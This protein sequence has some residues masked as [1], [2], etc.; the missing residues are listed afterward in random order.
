P[1]NVRIRLSSRSSARGLGW[2]VGRSR[3][4]IGGADR[5]IERWEVC[6]VIDRRE[7]LRRSS[8]LGVGA[9]VLG[10]G[11]LPAWASGSKALRGDQ[12]SSRAWPPAPQP[13]DGSWQS[14][15]PFSYSLGPLLQDNSASTV[16]NMSAPVD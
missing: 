8:A 6:E 1:A 2:S 4:A 14:M 9:A 10:G 3:R 15:V 11:A 5:S 12:R 16:D 13:S 7:F